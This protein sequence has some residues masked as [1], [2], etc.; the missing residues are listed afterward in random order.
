MAGLLFGCDLRMGACL[1]MLRPAV[2]VPACGASGCEPRAVARPGGGAV[3]R[4]PV[5]GREHGM[6]W[7]QGHTWAAPRAWPPGGRSSREGWYVGT[8]L[9]R[10]AAAPSRRGGHTGHWGCCTMM[11][12]FTAPCNHC[13]HYLHASYRDVKGSRCGG[14]AGARGHATLSSEMPGGAC[15]P[16]GV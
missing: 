15:V 11:R 9:F 2:W 16:C 12:L 14:P 8:T 5:A 13:K 1:V 6:G 4:Q 7:W 3:A 10:K